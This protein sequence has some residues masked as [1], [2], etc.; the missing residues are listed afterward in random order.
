MEDAAERVQTK[1]YV[2]SLE[3][4]KNASQTDK[5]SIDKHNTF[6]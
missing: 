5:Y 3:R 6:S 1:Y 4:L 2:S